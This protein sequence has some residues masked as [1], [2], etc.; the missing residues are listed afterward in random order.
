MKLSPYGRLE[1]HDV[2]QVGDEIRLDTPMS[3]LTQYCDPS[4]D[5]SRRK[6]KPVPFWWIG[7]KFGAFR[8]GCRG[9]VDCRRILSANG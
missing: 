2:M 1:D 8:R 7:K 3:Q 5:E 6:W 9:K 4:L